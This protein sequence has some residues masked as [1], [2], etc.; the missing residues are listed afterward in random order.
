[1]EWA[2]GRRLVRCHSAARGGA[3]FNPASTLHRFRPVSV[4]G[5]VVPTLYA[6]TTL[7]GALAETILRDVPLDGPGRAVMR[8]DLTQYRYSTLVP[9]RALRLA[10]LHDP[11]VRRLR[12]SGNEIGA[13]PPSCYPWTADWAQAIHDDTDADG[14]IWVPRNDNTARAVMLF[15]SRVRPGSLR[16]EADAQP[17]GAGVGLR[18][19]L[20]LL[21]ATGVALLD[22]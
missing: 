16:I 6:A 8:A 7:G 13:C 3:T 19:V 11:H 15:G 18:E 4:K 21:E 14:L 9:S 10:V 12:I 22:G 1:M 17:L 20:R 5:R 2:P